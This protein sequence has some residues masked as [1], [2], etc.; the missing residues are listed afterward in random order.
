MEPIHCLRELYFLLSSYLLIVA[1]STVMLAVDVSFLAVP[2]IDSNSVQS[3]SASQIIAYLSTLCAMGSLVVSLIL[4]SQIPVPNHEN[5]DSPVGTP[6]VC[7][8]VII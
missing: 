2:G 7:H 6:Y 8:V 3:Q 1:Q 5:G 4:G